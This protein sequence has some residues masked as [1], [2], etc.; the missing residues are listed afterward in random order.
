MF[1]RV[2]FGCVTGTYDTFNK[3][4]CDIDFVDVCVIYAEI[5]TRLSATALIHLLAIKTW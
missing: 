1:N 2:N 5:A 4:V 3:I